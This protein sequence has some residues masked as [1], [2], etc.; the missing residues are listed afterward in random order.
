MWKCCERA[1]RE[2]LAVFLYGG[3]AG[4]RAG[5]GD[6][7]ERIGID[8]ATGAA[9]GADVVILVVDGTA[10]LD[11][12]VA[13]AAARLDPARA[14]AVLSKSDLPGGA[15]IA[16]IER[17]RHRLSVIAVS[18]KTGEG[19]PA[20]KSALVARVGGE[21]LVRAARERVVLNARVAGL[22]RRA[23]TACAA[24]ASSLGRGTSHEL[25]AVE[26]RELLSCYEEALGRR[27]ADDVLDTIFS[28]F[29]IGK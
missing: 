21:A 25:L 14:V 27:Y 5:T 11:P 6:P 22:L 19:I 28:R 3:T 10:G 8:R 16:H 15:G 13:E 9:A 26:A 23:D 20:L 2:G 17:V 7:V 29:C 4:L 18:A 24:L 12:V 1:E